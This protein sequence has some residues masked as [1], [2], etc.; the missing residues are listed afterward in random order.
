MTKLTGKTCSDCGAPIWRK[1]L[2]GR[3]LACSMARSR[4]RKQYP[5]RKHT[6]SAPLCVDGTRAHHMV[7]ESPN[8]TGTVTGKC[9]RCGRT[10][11]LPT[12]GGD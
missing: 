9:K 1:S 8:G 5:N 3:C 10:Q 6:S 2:T 11:V 7:F 12:T 4:H